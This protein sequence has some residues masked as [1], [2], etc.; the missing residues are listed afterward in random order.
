MSYYKIIRALIIW[1]VLC[2]LLNC[3]SE[4][5]QGVSL[6]IPACKNDT[7]IGAVIEQPF[8]LVKQIH[9]NSCWA[10]VLSMMFSWKEGKIISE[11]VILSPYDEYL[12]IYKNSGKAGI[13][14]KQ[15]IALYQEL[16]LETEKQLNPTIK[17]WT[18]MINTY[19][20]L[21]ITID[22]RPP[23][24]TIHAILILAIYGSENGLN[25][26]VIYADPADGKL[27]EVDFLAFLKMYESKYSVDWP[28]QI[29]HFKHK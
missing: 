25:T 8:F 29:I 13:T 2:L 6:I 11:E 23:F 24:G 22:A 17:G 4:K 26:R 5:L 19:G 18:E 1:F 14:F 21:S 3:S 10:S 9:E 20:P 27:H 16:G 7:C 15:E 28:I 12:E